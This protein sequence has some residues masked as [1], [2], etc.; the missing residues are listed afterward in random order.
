MNMSFELTDYYSVRVQLPRLGLT[1]I[2]GYYDARCESRILGIR[3]TVLPLLNWCTM[4][5]SEFSSLSKLI[6]SRL[7]DL[8]D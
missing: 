2:S 6:C 8:I 7:R 1:H 3:T 5:S 4:D